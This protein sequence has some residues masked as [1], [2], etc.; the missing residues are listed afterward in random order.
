[1]SKRLSTM[2]VAIVASMALAVPV[3]SQARTDR[4]TYRAGDSTSTS[5]E[6]IVGGAETPI[7][8]VGALGYFFVT[9]SGTSFTLNVDDFGTVDGL[10][11]AVSVH[12]SDGFLFIGCLPVRSTRT[13]TGATAGQPATVWIENLGP[14]SFPGSCSGM[15]TAGVATVTGVN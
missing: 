15:A 14:R 3:S 10:E 2:V 11:V 4:Y 1:M 8:H 7:G 9:P 12:T 6:P 5:F 13:I